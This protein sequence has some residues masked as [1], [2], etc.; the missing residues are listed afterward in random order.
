MYKENWVF[1][2]KNSGKKVLEQN[3]V[4]RDK[5]QMDF[6]YQKQLEGFKINSSNNFEIK[7]EKLHLF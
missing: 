2:D 7:R 3:R 1:I 6:Y 4:A 5:E